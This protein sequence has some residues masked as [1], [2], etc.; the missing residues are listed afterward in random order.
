MFDELPVQ[1]VSQLVNS[2]VHILID[3]VGEQVFPADVNACLGLLF[4]LF[5]RQYDVGA[6]DF[7]VVVGQAFKLVGDIVFQSV[8]QIQVVAADIDLHSNILFGVA[9]T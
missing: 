8:S 2:G 4:Q 7:V 6:G 3:G 9:I 5:H 1:F